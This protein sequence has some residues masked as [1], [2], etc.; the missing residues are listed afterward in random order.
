M[1]DSSILS[2]AREKNVNLVF[3]ETLEYFTVES[4]LW[5][6][7]RIPGKE[8]RL[9]PECEF[10]ASKRMRNELGNL[11]RAFSGEFATNLFQFPLKIQ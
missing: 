5:K 8:P 11:Y 2:W 9:C 1:K 4:K 6:H 3:A 10:K 7:S